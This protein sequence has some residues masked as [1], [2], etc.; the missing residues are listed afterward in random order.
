[1]RDTKHDAYVKSLNR[2]RSLD[3]APS[4][5]TGNP[6]ISMKIL[7]KAF[8]AF[9]AFVCLAELGGSDISLAWTSVLGNR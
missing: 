3:F 9:R 4:A 2:V 7:T 1:M 5:P 8:K 6:S